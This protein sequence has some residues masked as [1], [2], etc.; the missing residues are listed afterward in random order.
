MHYCTIN[1]HLLI[2][3][4]TINAHLMYNKAHFFAIN[5]QLMHNKAH[6]MYNKAHFICNKCTVYLQ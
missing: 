6:L 3:K 4:C 1:A 2:Y 5:V